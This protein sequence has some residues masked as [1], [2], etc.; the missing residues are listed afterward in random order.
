MP[1]IPRRTFALVTVVLCAALWYLSSPSAPVTSVFSYFDIR[2]TSSTPE[3]YG[4]LHRILEAEDGGGAVVDEHAIGLDAF[5]TE[6]VDWRKEKALLDREY[7]VVIFSK[8]RR[9]S[10]PLILLH[11]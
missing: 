8:V 10:M 2:G 11:S 4:L 5:A 7:P 1:P 3:I 9:A 6:K